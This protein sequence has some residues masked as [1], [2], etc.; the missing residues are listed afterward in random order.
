MNIE[1]TAQEMEYL[2]QE[3]ADENSLS[4]DS[5]MSARDSMTSNQLFRISS[6]D[7]KKKSSEEK[8][9]DS[10][11]AKLIDLIKLNVPSV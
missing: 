7:S 6:C 3:S 5:S 8:I 2:A 11:G 10:P 1:V 4:S 9:C